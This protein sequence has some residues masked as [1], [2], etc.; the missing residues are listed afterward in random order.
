MAERSLADEAVKLS[1]RVNRYFS[2]VAGLSRVGEGEYP[3]LILQGKLLLGELSLL[4]KKI[5]E[6]GAGNLAFESLNGALALEKKD[7]EEV[8][9]ALEKADRTREAAD[10]EYMEY[11]IGRIKNNE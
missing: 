8:I 10:R 4:E 6:D 5:K 2:D 1:E 9:G 11:L 7:L 3:M